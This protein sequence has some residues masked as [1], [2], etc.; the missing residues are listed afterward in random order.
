MVLAVVLA[1]VAEVSR[2][3]TLVGSLD[4]RIIDDIFLTL[5]LLLRFSGLPARN[6]KKYITWYCRRYK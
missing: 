4:A 1:E 2:T 3:S 6:T 5:L